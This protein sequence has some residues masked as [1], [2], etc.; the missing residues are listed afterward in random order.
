VAPEL[1]SQFY[2]GSRVIQIMFQSFKAGNTRVRHLLWP[3]DLAA[4]CL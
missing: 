3:L 4:F 2:T 1:F